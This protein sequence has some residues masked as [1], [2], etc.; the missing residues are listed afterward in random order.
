MVREA[1]AHIPAADRDRWW[2]IAYGVDQVAD[3][4]DHAALP[5]GGVPYLPCGVEHV[6]ATIEHTKMGASDVFVDVGSGLGRVT[7]LAHL[8]TGASA[9]GLE[10]Q[11]A[12]VD[13]SRSLAAALHADRVVVVPGDAV[14][15]ARYM[16]IG[17]VF[18]LYCP[19][20][21]ARLDEMVDSLADVARTRT[22]RIA[23]VSVTL[24]PRPWLRVAATPSAELIIY[25]SA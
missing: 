15:L 25:E 3:D 6:L 5:P 16:M 13:A 23:C 21:G 20:S 9:I 1:L 18:F 24:S 7:T 19:F 22:I 4:D 14:Q 10:V 17:T 2:D 11:P 8:L 12:L